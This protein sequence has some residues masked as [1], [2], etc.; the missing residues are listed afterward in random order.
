MADFTGT[1]REIV[2]W[3]M[4]KD[5]E[6]K[7]EV[8]KIRKRRSPT[9]NAYYWSMLNQ[10]ARKL[11]ISDTETHKH[12][13]REYGVCDVVL[14][15]ADIEPKDYFE[16]FDSVDAGTIKG[17]RYKQVKVYKRSSRMD[18]AEF[19]ALI[20]GMRYECEQQGID[21]MTPE[22]IARLRFVEPR[23]TED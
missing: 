12:M 19:S 1:P 8:K 3:L 17:I 11:R 20:D 2:V 16:Y 9:Q 10:L 6:T 13:L 5:P 22:E 14:L 21:V 18:S 15:R 23:E 4:G 7:Y